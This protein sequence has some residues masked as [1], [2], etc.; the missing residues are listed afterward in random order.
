ML[1]LFQRLRSLSL[2]LLCALVLHPQMAQ[3]QSSALPLRDLR[4]NGIGW[5]MVQAVAGSV[6]SNDGLAYGSTEVETRTFAGSFTAQSDADRLAVFSDDGCDVYVNGFRYL[7]LK[8]KGQHLPDLS[9]SLHKVPFDFKKDV[10]YSIRIEFSNVSYSGSSDIDGVTLY[11]YKAYEPLPC[12]VWSH[13]RWAT[14]GGVTQTGPDSEPSISPSS[15][16]EEVKWTD[17]CMATTKPN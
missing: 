10:E 6:T 1:P 7:T 4:S 8:G 9:Q 17:S 5:M 13:V 16:T 15:A 11:A 14:T 3:A 12:G 2:F